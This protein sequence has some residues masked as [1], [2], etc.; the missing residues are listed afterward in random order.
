MSEAAPVI[1]QVEFWNGDVGQKW[2]ANQERMDGA[3]TPLTKFLIDHA[4]AGPGEH[5][6][7]VGCGA[8][9]V[10]LELARLVGRSGHVLA[11]DISRPLLERARARDAAQTGPDRAR[12][13]WREA[14]AGTFAFER[15]GFDLI[16][17][18]FGT[19]FFADPVAAFANLRGALRPGGRLAMLCWR[20]MPE[21]DWVS[22]PRTAILN[23]LP[24]P[25]PVPPEAP[26]P[27]A[28]AD[29][30]RVGAILARSGWTGIRS[31][32]I[33]G[34]LDLGADPEER[35]RFVTELGPASA[36]LRDVP[37]DL[38]SRALASVRAALAGRFAAGDL[39]T[40]AACW[41]YTARNGAA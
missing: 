15:G 11:V 29:A 17:S 40:R 1:D 20:T 12:I 6:L 32:L 35:A 26:G 37:G 23:V 36:L 39:A 24:P 19:M 41:V 28:F 14:D 27:F 10:S 16:V 33:D 38:R 31:H 5:V 34:A 4:Q 30:A 2:A 3:F 18:R 25:P 22:V 8:G 7:D 9:F 21:N 13:E